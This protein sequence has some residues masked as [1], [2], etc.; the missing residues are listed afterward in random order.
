MNNIFLIK[1]VE[2]VMKVLW[3][4]R[5]NI[6]N[7]KFIHARFFNKYLKRN[8]IL[9]ITISEIQL[10]QRNKLCIFIGLKKGR[11]G[12]REILQCKRVYCLSFDISKSNFKKE[13]IY[14]SPLHLLSPKQY[15][16]ENFHNPILF[17]QNPDESYLYRLA[18]FW[19]P[20]ILKNTLL[21]LK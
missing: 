5:A 9:Y 6:F 13:E 20:D 1:K 16:L 11:G 14:L 21:L 7:A 4:W 15:K 17:L 8:W 3:K 2:E 19:K 10:F 18:K 12:R